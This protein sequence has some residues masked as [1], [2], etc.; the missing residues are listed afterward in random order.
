MTPKPKLN[1]V[2]RTQPTFTSRQVNES[3]A[4]SEVLRKANQGKQ[5]SHTPQPIIAQ[6][7]P[8]PCAN[9]NQSKLLVNLEIPPPLPNLNNRLLPGCSHR[10][11][12]VELSNLQWPFP[13]FSARGTKKSQQAPPPANRS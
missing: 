6:E 10:P 9:P 3:R 1:N 12:P 8:L 5:V 13:K 7:E 4:Y 11:L 2:T